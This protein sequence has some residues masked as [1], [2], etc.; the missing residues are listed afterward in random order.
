MLEGSSYSSSLPQDWGNNTSPF[1]EL[2]LLGIWAGN[3]LRLG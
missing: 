3:M 2:P 1:A